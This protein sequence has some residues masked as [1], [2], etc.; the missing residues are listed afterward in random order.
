MRSFLEEVARDLYERYGAGIADRSILFPSRRARLFFVD[1]LGGIADRPMWEPQWTT[2]DELMSEISG[3]RTGDRVRLIV[4]LY[5]VYSEYHAEPFDKFYFWGDMLLTDFDTIDKYLIDADMLFRNIGEIKELEADISYLTPAQLQILAFWS[6]FGA[7]ADLSEEKRRFL[8]LWKTLGPIYR[9][10]RERLAG[11]GIAYNGMVQRAAADRIREGAFAFPEPRRYVVA[12]FN[13]LSECEKRLFRFLS[14]AAETDFYWDYDTYY[15]ERPEQ[16]AGMFV[17]Q[18]VVQFPPRA[19]LSHDGMRQPKELTAVASV[20]NAVQCK[21]AARILCDLAGFDEQGRFVEGRSRRLDKRTAVVLTDENL[22][23]P[24]LYALP[25]ELGR[26]NVTMGYP[27]RAT[28]A[29]TFVE[30]LVELQNRRRSKGGG[31]T[32][33]HADVTGLL[34]H[35]YVS[36]ADPGLAGE[37]QEQI[38]RER[39][40]SVDGAWLA[41]S[42][43]LRELFAPAEGWRA[44]S[45]YLLRM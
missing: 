42:E 33:Y 7:D 12:G 37:M 28:L 6:S 20:S 21:Y 39:R 18:N 5:K 1:A 19:E 9:R 23:M 11:L 17:R 30:R 45:D 2:I 13:A 32:F 3:L 38:V 43:L 36:E 14:T 22:L 41:R 44:L 26:V 40:I 10:Y 34:A 4:E 27:L 16:E 35:P 25:P 29:Y 31:S 8:A 24:L 15:K